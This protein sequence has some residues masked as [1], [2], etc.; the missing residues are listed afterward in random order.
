MS[1][2]PFNSNQPAASVVV[3][4]AVPAIET[5]TPATGSDA[6]SVTR[7]DTR[8]CI[9]EGPAT[10]VPA[11]DVSGPMRDGPTSS[12]G[13]VLPHDSP[14]MATTH[15]H[16]AR[17]IMA[18]VLVPSG[19]SARRA[20][21]AGAWRAHDDGAGVVRNVV[22]N[23]TIPWS[24]RKSCRRPHLMYDPGPAR[25]WCDCTKV[26]Q[27]ILVC[28]RSAAVRSVHGP[29]GRAGAS[30]T[31]YSQRPVV[32]RTARAPRRPRH[33]ADLARRLA[34]A[35]QCRGAGAIQPA[36]QPERPAPGAWLR[37]GSDSFRWTAADACLRSAERG[38]RRGCLRR[39]HRAR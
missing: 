28:V 34:V 18:T 1:M 10:G 30:A 12:I 2:S 7:P 8:R 6:V 22:R 9:V 29:E 31:P 27:P 21:A 17:R 26:D 24:R 16:A 38:G 39:G 11:T 35:R 33:R 20:K 25:H 14:N 15:M 36:A 5:C 32:A 4:S 19:E 3:L 23:A 37:G 13:S